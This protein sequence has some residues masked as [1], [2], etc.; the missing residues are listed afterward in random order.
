LRTEALRLENGLREIENAI[1]RDREEADRLAIALEQWDR[2]RTEAEQTCRTMASRRQDLEEKVGEIASELQGA[3]RLLDKRR[4]ERDEEQTNLAAHEHSLRELRSRLNNLQEQL[5]NDQVRELEIRSEMDRVRERILQEFKVDLAEEVEKRRQA[6]AT[7]GEP[8]AEE[9]SEIDAEQQRRQ[10]EELRQKLLKIGLVN[11]LA[12]EEYDRQ[13]ERLLFHRQQ[14]EDLRKA[15]QDLLDAIAQIN[16]TAG[17]MFEET[18]EQA[19]LRFREVFE[20]LF[21]GGEADLLF[22]GDDPLEGTIE[23]KARP[24][25]KKLEAI[26]LLSTGERALTAI[27]LL[28]GIY[29]V[30]PSPFCILDELDAPLD[31]ANIRRFVELLRH[32]SGRTQ[33]VVITHNKRTME[34][35]DRLYGVTMQEAGI[36]KIVSVQLSDANDELTPAA[37]ELLHSSRNEGPDA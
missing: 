6:D 23:I 5:H 35:A 18:F 16:E 2:E 22:L 25:G 14:R 32:F 20:T 26:R 4:S 30:K 1:S 31:D 21:P 29:L 27:A 7:A 13:K 33:F 10:V 12:A 3:E 28:F 34:A 19:R 15:R 36:S 24:R 17:R 9:S 8:A 11:F 37:E